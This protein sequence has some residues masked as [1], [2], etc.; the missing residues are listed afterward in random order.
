M[1]ET[2]AITRLHKGYDDISRRQLLIFEP[3]FSYFRRHIFVD[4]AVG[5]ATRYIVVDLAPSVFYCTYD[6][7]IGLECTSI[8]GIQGGHRVSSASS[9]LCAGFSI[10]LLHSHIDYKYDCTLPFH[11]ELRKVMNRIRSLR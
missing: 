8:F 2:V 10:L 9:H 3:S 1:Y 7:W 4:V 5:E 6:G 11:N